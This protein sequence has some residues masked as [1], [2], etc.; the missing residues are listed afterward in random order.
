MLDRYNI[1]RIRVTKVTSRLARTDPIANLVP[2]RQS[3]IE[4]IPASIPR[5][6][7]RSVRIRPRRRINP[8]T[9]R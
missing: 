6:L 7:D 3:A 2:T 4:P 5:P 8:T 9:G 1:K